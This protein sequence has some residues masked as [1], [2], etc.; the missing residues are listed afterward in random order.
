LTEQ[1]RQRVEEKRDVEVNDIYIAES[2]LPNGGILMD[3]PKHTRDGAWIG[4][5]PAK[6]YII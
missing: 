2:I 1:L 4:S 6:A 3:A 5:V